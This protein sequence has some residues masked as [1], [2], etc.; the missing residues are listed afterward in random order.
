MKKLNQKGFS[1]IEGLLIIIVILMI[2]FIGYYVWHTQKDANKTLDTATKSAQTSSSSPSKQTKAA[3]QKYLDIKE[4]GVKFKLSD[5]IKDAYY[6]KG[7]NDYYYVS[8]H[9]FD[10]NPDLAGCMATDN[11]TY[12]SGLMA[13]I[14]AKLGE[15][16]GSFAGDPWTLDSIKQAGLKQVG[17]S[18]Y[19]FQHGNGPCWNVEAT[20]ADAISQQASDMIQAFVTATPT[21]TKD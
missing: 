9:S 5:A 19:G 4:L 7:S 2:G 14:V 8:V 16:N 17:D 21:F 1:A 20:N 18:Y 3:D 11:G 12:G 15:P 13:V 6:I 10:N